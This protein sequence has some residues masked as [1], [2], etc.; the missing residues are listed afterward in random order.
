MRTLRH[1]LRQPRLRGLRPLLG[2]L[3]V[4]SLFAASPVLAQADDDED[5]FLSDDFL[6]DDEFED[7][8]LSDDFAEEVTEEVVRKKGVYYWAFEVPVDVL[9][10][11]PIALADVA[12]GGGFFTIIAPE[13]VM[14]AGAG[15][16]WDLARGKD[17]YFDTGT[18]D[19]ALEQAVTNPAQYLFDRPLGQLTSF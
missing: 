8:F 13:L 9:V 3:L 2:L 18:I 14:G 1:S 16:L 12:I 7:D 17:W 10:L 19:W 6:H 5:D 11:R 15:A 4:C